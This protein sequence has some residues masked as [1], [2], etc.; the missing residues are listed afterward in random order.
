M[1]I[2]VC[3]FCCTVNSCELRYDVNARPY[4]TCRYCLSRSFFHSLEALRGLAIVPGL[5]ES[6][7]RRRAAEP[8][9][10]KLIDGQIASFVKQVRERTLP[11]TPTAAERK[12]RK[13]LPAEAEPE[14][15][16]FD[17]GAAGGR[18]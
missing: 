11:D 16:P 13:G 5:L 1:R 8:E 14:I 3:P 9:Y 17:E 12:A 18:T 10:R 6:A 7:L 4:I 2:K 15:I